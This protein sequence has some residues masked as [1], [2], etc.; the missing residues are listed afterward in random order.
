GIREKELPNGRKVASEVTPL[1]D[2]SLRDRLDNILVS[3][4]VPRMNWRIH[5]IEIGPGFCLVVEIKASEDALHQVS[6]YGDN[7]YY[8]RTEAGVHPMGPADIDR[9]YALIHRQKAEDDQTVRG[10][11]EE[12]KQN[13]SH[14]HAAVLLIPLDVSSEIVNPA[15]AHSKGDGL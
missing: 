10:I 3:A 13:S 6:A 11:L 4:V 7:R 2:G 9:A 12:E 8:K 5:R 14:G 1:S 15:K